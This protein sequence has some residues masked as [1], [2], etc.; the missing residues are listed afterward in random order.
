MRSGENVFQR[1]LISNKMLSFCGKQEHEI[2]NYIIY[3]KFT[4]NK[5]RIDHAPSVKISTQPYA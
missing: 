3:A 1:E 5:I 2:S 4:T